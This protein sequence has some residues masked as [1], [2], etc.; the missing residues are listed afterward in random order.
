VLH[1][2]TLSLLTSTSP[3]PA[4]IRHPPKYGQRRYSQLSPSL[5][6]PASPSKY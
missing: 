1:F 3:P 5:I 2:Q 4:R 6:S